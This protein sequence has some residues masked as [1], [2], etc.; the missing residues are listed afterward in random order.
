MIK[1]SV[2]LPFIMTGFTLANSINVAKAIPISKNV[3]C[4]AALQKAKK[5][6][7]KN[8]KVNVV[9]TG[10]ED[11][12][13][14][15]KNYPTNRPFSYQFGLTGPATESI[16]NSDKFLTII[17][18]NIID[19]CPSIS[20]VEFGEHHTDHVA[21]YGLLS[22]NKVGWFKCIGENDPGTTIK[23]MWGQV[24]CI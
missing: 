14:D 23:T 13:Q 22:N 19:N 8:R 18:K 24:V 9:Y 11:I 3:E 7:Q 6:L 5:Q 16:L 17:A 2:L 1:I 12:S 20:M 10:Q 21:T 4:N 15:Y